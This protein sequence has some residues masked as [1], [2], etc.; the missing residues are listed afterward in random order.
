MDLVFHFLSATEQLI[1]FER[2][3]ERSMLPKEQNNI[4]QL[5]ASWEMVMKM[6][7]SLSLT[8]RYASIFRCLV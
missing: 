7:P 6:V 1:F 2:E 8:Q 5:S 3:R 4:V